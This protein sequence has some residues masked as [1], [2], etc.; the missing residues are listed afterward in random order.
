MQS[1][2]F[3]IFDNLESNNLI[4]SKTDLFL[5]TSTHKTL[6]FYNTFMYIFSYFGIMLT[7]VI[8][9]RELIDFEDN[10]ISIIFN[11]L[12]I[13]FLIMLG[14][15]KNN[16]NYCLVIKYIFYI[17]LPYFSMNEL[18]LIFEN[19]SNFTN[20][21]EAIISKINDGTDIMQQNQYVGWFMVCMGILTFLVILFYGHI[22]ALG[23]PIIGIFLYLFCFALG[24]LLM[25]VFPFCFFFYQIICFFIFLPLL[26]AY[27][28]YYILTNFKYIITK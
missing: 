10:L 7:Y 28:F 27:D 22:V 2:Q 4:L 21:F 24:F 23:I 25:I 1:N 5:G 16:K 18:F 20:I 9:E 17:S 3:Q 6:L 14:I 13:L 26:I 12:G 8:Y 19:I 11:S 15:F